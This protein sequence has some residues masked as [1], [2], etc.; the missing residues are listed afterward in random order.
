MLTEPPEYIK[1]WQKLT[2]KELEKLSPD[3][4]MRA[5][6]WYLSQE[7]EMRAGLIEDCRRQA[8]EEMDQERERMY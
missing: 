3:E 7:Q 2:Q 5:I 8:R 1:Q 4:H 6:E